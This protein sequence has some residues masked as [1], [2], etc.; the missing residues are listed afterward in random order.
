MTIPYDA[1]DRSCIEC[2]RD[3]EDYTGHLHASEV[4]LCEE[5]YPEYREKWQYRVEVVHKVPLT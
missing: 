1:T 5:C 3:V 4:T 2:S